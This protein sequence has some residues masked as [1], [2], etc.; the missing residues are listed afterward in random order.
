MQGYCFATKVK[1][2]DPMESELV[3][4]VSC[5]IFLS[6]RPA[7]LNKGSVRHGN[8]L[9]P[10]KTNLNKFQKVTSCINFEPLWILTSWS[11][12]CNT[13][14]KQW[15]FA[16]SWIPDW[17]PPAQQRIIY[18]KNYSLRDPYF[19]HKQTYSCLSV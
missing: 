6:H 17:F 13:F 15:A 5:C 19:K 9:G 18:N 2:L 12:P 3:V 1:I 14:I 4:H 11:V 8:I 16:W 10:L 7:Q